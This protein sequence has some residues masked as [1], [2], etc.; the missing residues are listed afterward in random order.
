MYLS[1][2]EVFCDCSPGHWRTQLH[3]FSELRRTHR[4]YQRRCA[5]GL[6]GGVW[7]LR[8]N[9]CD[10][11]SMRVWESLDCKFFVYYVLETL[12]SCQLRRIG[13]TGGDSVTRKRNDESGSCRFS[14]Y[15]PTP[16]GRTKGLSEKNGAGVQ[17]QGRSWKNRLASFNNR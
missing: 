14:V 9:S 16:L 6:P 8:T 4:L 11:E 10:M 17:G 5:S 7:F 12:G 1:P 3:G 2:F 13:Y 15:R